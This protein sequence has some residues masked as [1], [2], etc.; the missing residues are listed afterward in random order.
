M[1]LC[2][3]R[4]WGRLTRKNW[5]DYQGEGLTCCATHVPLDRMKNET[6]AVID[7][8]KLWNCKYTAIGGFFQNDF[9]TQDWLDFAKN[10]NEA[11]KLFAGSGL[12][13]GYHN[14]SHELVRFDGKTGLQ[15]YWTT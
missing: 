2:R 5:R 8:H 7:E 10:Y 4:H 14:H 15:I 9:K 1:M 3:R 13:I 12:T 6:Q 11:A